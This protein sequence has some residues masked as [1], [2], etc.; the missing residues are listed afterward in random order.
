MPLELIYDEQWSTY[1]E[2]GRLQI[3]Q[4]ITRYF[5]RR[6]GSCVMLDSSY[7]EED[8]VECSEEEAIVKMIEM[9]QHILETEHY[10]ANSISSKI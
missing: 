10:M 6:S 8:M 3:Y 4:D 5:I 9:D 2:Y 1:E 7:Y